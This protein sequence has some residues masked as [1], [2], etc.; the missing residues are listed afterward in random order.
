MRLNHKGITLIEILIVFALIGVVLSLG[1]SFALFGKKTFDGGEKQ[2]EI[3]FDARMVS[4]FITDELRNATSL[5][6]I[7]IPASFTNDNFNYIYII[8]NQLVH[9]YN[10]VVTNKTGPTLTEMNPTFS[11]RKLGNNNNIVT[12]NIKSTINSAIGQ[13]EIQISSDIQLNNL[14]GLADDQDHAVKYKKP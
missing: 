1:Y 3:Q 6:L 14:S 8:N 2:S 5:E 7:S 11:M 4:K 10:G 12:F 13:K 9:R